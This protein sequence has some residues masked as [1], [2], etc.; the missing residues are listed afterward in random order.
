MSRL[1][2]VMLN[3]SILWAKDVALRQKCKP[4]DVKSP[5]ELSLAQSLIREMFRTLYADPSGIALAAPQVGVLLQIVVISYQDRD[6]NEHR[7]MALINPSIVNRSDEV[8]ED[9]EIC[10]SVPNFTGKVV[11]ANTVEVEAFNQH[12]E[13]IRFK[14]EGFLARVIQHELDHLSGVL[15]ADIVKGKLEPIPDFP[16]RRLKHTMKKLSLADKG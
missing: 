11:R 2:I 1:P 15:Y 9:Q 8:N 7:L 6:T 14:A 10:L 13:P 12:G 4:V 3:E 16:E 5:E